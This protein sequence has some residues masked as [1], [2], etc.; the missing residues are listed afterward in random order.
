MSKNARNGFQFGSW[1]KTRRVSNPARKRLI[2]DASAV[3]SELSR[4][5]THTRV[6]A[7]ARLSEATQSMANLDAKLHDLK[8]KLRRG[9]LQAAV[10]LARRDLQLKAK[11]LFKARETLAEARKANALVRGSLAVWKDD[12]A[13]LPPIEQA[14]IL[15]SSESEATDT[16]T[17]RG[18]RRHPPTNKRGVASLGLRVDESWTTSIVLFSRPLICSG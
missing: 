16:K 5:R 13:S 4:L 18:R 14:S 17:S 7:Q 10:D 3:E 15:D 11:A 6:A 9:T 1:W 12:K 8:D 2:D